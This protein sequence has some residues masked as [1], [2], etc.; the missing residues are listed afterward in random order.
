MSPRPQS[1]GRHDASS[2][3]VR[4]TNVASVGQGRTWGTVRPERTCNAL[5][6]ANP[7]AA[8]IS[9]SFTS[10]RR[11]RIG[12]NAARS[13]R[14]ASGCSPRQWRSPAMAVAMARPITP[15][16]VTAR[17]ST[18]DLLVSTPTGSQAR[19]VAQSP[20]G[21]ACWVLEPCGH[22]LLVP[23][24][25]DVSVT[26]PEHVRCPDHGIVAIAKGCA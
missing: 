7:V 4:P 24:Q 15:A 14:C 2:G 25:P 21:G 26:P 1:S 10:T 23:Y 20:R 19:P 3:Q 22:P 11:S 9:L 6:F 5:D 13:G 16:A 8:M 12:P 18:H 17:R